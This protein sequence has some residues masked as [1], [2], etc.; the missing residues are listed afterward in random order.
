MVMDIAWPMAAAVVAWWLGTGVILWLDRQGPVALRAGLVVWSLLL[1]MALYGARISMTATS[2][3]H[4]YLGFFSAIA[5]WGWHE[6]VFLSGRLTGP[7]RIAMSVGATGLERFKQAFAAVLWHELALVANAAL[8]W[9]MHAQQPNHVALCTFG[10]LWCL[11]L[12]AK[13]NLFVGVPLVGAQYLPA[14]LQYM[15]SYFKVAQVG[16]WYRLTLT[17]ATAGWVAL[18]WQ[19][20]GA[21]AADFTGW[22]LLCTLFGLGILEMLIMVL[23]WP[24]QQLWGWM[25]RLPDPT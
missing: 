21:S 6:L 9:L 8:L 23:P 12:V 22:V 10:L 16:W 25:I 4:A 20:Q 17:L 18:I 24:V 5:M 11:R 2:S 13:L 1:L 3:A 19:T 7:R 15:A 14:H